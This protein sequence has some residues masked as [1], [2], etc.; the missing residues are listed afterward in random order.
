MPSNSA[1]A[2]KHPS[3]SRPGGVAEHS[4]AISFQPAVLMKSIADDLL[5][6]LNLGCEAEANSDGRRILR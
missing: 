6:I 2:A 3:P 4:S 1:G 5:K